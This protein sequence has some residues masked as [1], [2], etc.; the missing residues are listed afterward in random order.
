MELQDLYNELK[1]ILQT[2]GYRIGE[3]E[4]IDYGMQFGIDNGRRNLLR[5][6]QNKKGRVKY[7]YSQLK[8]DPAE[9]IIAL[10]EGKRN[11]QQHDLD[12]PLI[13]S[14][15]AGKG[16]YFGPLVCAAV[17][18]DKNAAAGL[19]R[20][21]VRDSKTMDDTDI[22]LLQSQIEK[23]VSGRYEIVELAPGLYNQKIEQYRQRGQKLNHLLANMHAFAIERLLKKVQCNNILVDKFADESLMI[24]ALSAKSR[25]LHLVQLPS[26]EANIAVAAASVMAR[27]RYVRRLSQLS[28]QYNIDLG[29]GA[30]STIVEQGRRFVRKHGKKEL[31]QIAKLHFKTT[32]QLASF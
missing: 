28:S 26:A 2:A 12:F 13:G 1:S 27:G 18:V 15:E 5:V 11:R 21:G 20:L 10:I 4:P 32:Q 3:M 14:D 31:N 23:L 25:A 17:H 16:D 8:G 30:S 9:E 29:K 19:I 6:Y 22:L 24:Q 7:D